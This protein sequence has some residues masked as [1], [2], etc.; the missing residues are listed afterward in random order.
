MESKRFKVQLATSQEIKPTI[1][2]IKSKN[3][4]VEGS[5]PVQPLHL[6]IPCHIDSDQ[7]FL[8]FCRA[9]E[10]VSIQIDATFTVFVGISGPQEQRDSA[11]AFMARLAVNAS[12]NLRWYIQDDELEKRSQ[13]EHLRYLLQ[14]GSS[15]INPNAFITFL[16]NDDMCHPLRLFNMSN[17]YEHV[18]QNVGDNQGTATLALPCKLLLDPNISRKDGR[19]ENFVDV[20][21]HKAIDLANYNY[22]KK[23]PP[24]RTRKLYWVSNELAKE[25]DAEE[26][27]DFIVP[28]SVL[29]KF[30]RLTPT[31]VANHK[32]CDLRLFQ[33]L[34]YLQPMEMGDVN[35]GMWMLVH[36][37]I[38]H[39]DKLR[40]FDNHGQLERHEYYQS[41]QASF[42]IQSPTPADIVL[43]ESFSK[44]SP[45][46]IALCRGHLESIILS[47][48]GWNDQELEK[49][50]NDK[51]NELNNRHGIGFGDALWGE[52]SANIR[53]LFDDETLQASNGTWICA[54]S[55]YEE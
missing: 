55:G 12:E 49:V 17:A 36:Y 40:A 11:V 20:R 39:D 38:P 24:A 52:C 6:L 30:F 31:T 48:I 22:W 19:L 15:P 44:L 34:S 18:T 50:K 28:S 1:L 7:R 3:L 33:V 2:G 4:T 41:E 16:D 25:T 9:A 21:A 13:M 23:S 47:Y 54:W 51:V 37:K 32:F 42:D 26:Y 35:P 5:I 29:Q 45:S 53:S 14:D 10:S 43:A 8:L 27:F 46:Q